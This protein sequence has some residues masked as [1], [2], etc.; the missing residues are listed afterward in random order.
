M[1]RLILPGMAFHVVQRGNQSR[2]CVSRI[3][4]GGVALVERGRTLGPVAFL[5][6]MELR[7][8]RSATA[9]A[10]SKTQAGGAEEGLPNF[11]V[12]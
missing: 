4:I 6:D 8:R 11:V 9:A 2:R 5:D 10:R 12:E 7:L 1:A 3:N